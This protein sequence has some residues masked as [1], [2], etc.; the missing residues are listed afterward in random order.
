MDCIN[1]GGNIVGGW[2]WATPEEGNPNC[3]AA[4]QDETRSNAGFTIVEDGHWQTTVERDVSSMS[5]TERTGC[6][7]PGG[8]PQDLS[9]QHCQV[10]AP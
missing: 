4:Y 9:H 1:Q 7:N 8:Q 10:E 6:W 2:D 5:T 3:V